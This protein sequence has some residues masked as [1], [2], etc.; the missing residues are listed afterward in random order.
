M[1]VAAA[2]FGN[3]A[4]DASQPHKAGKYLTQAAGHAFNHKS[5][6]QSIML[7]LHVSVSVTAGFGNWLHVWQAAAETGGS[8]LHAGK[9]HK[10]L[11][12]LLGTSGERQKPHKLLQHPGAAVVY[13]GCT[14]Q[15]QDL[16]APTTAGNLQQLC[17]RRRGGMAA[18]LPPY[19]GKRV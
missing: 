19:P 9:P 11:L 12:Q 4:L 15:I 13:G 18:N 3:I 5:G 6:Y 2:G 16:H 10:Q 8:A 14:K 7:N 17:S 1:S